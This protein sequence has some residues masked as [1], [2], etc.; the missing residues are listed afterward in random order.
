MG[1]IPAFQ[2]LSDTARVAQRAAYLEEASQAQR[3]C[4]THFQ[5]SGTRLKS[6]NALVP[7][8]LVKTFDTLTRIMLSEDTTPSQFDNAVR[9]LRMH[10]PR[11]HGW[12]E[13]WLKPTVASMIFPAKTVLDPSVMAEVPN[14]SNP[15]EHQHYLLHHATGIDHDLIK[16]IENI[17]L[18]VQEMEAQ[19]K[20]IASAYN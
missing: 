6:N 13:W 20:A 4:V 10:F 17:Y 12:L 15:I 8:E 3:G 7:V 11:I 14:T 9:Q 18:H 19:Y 2:N 16:G 5:R 1:L